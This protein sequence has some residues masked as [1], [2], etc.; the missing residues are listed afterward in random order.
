M[1]ICLIRRL[2]LLNELS[3]FCLANSGIGQL[4]FNLGSSLQVGSLPLGTLS[5]SKDP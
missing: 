5:R 4:R 2:Y 1:S 3:K